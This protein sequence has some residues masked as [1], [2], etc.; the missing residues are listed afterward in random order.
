MGNA[1]IERR[2]SEL[3]QKADVGQPTITVVM[4]QPEH[5]RKPL[6]EQTGKVRILHLDDPNDPVAPQEK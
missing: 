1:R 2:I 3:E 6:E 4:W 5:C